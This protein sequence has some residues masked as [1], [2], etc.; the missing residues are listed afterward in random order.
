[1][2]NGASFALGK[3]DQAFSFDGVDDYVWAP[4][5][6][7]DDLQTLTIEAWVKLNSL[8]DRIQ[9]FVTLAPPGL[10]RAVLRYGL[11]GTTEPGQ[12]HFYM[13]IG[14]ESTDFTHLA[15]DGVLQSGV[16]HHVAGTYDGNYMRLYLDGVEVGSIEIS[17]PVATGTHHGV[18]LSSPDEPLD[19]LLDEVSIY[20]RALSASEILAIY[21]A[22]PSGKCSIDRLISN[23]RLHPVTLDGEISSSTEWSDTVPCQIALD[24]V[25]GWPDRQVEPSSKVLTARFKNDD[26]WLYLLYQIPWPIVDDFSVDPQDSASISLFWGSYVPPWDYSDASRLSFGGTTYDVYGWD[27]THWYSDTEASPPG[28]NDV[29]GAASHDGTYYWFEFKKRLDSGDGRDWSFSPGELMG[30]PYAPAETPHLIVSVWDNSII[31]NYEQYVSLQLSPA[32]DYGETVTLRLEREDW[33]GGTRFWLTGSVYPFDGEHQTATLQIVGPHGDVTFEDIALDQAGSYRHESHFQ[34]DRGYYPRGSLADSGLYRVSVFYGRARSEAMLPVLPPTGSAIIVA[35]YGPVRRNPWTGVRENSQPAVNELADWAYMVMLGRLKSH[36][37]IYLLHPDSPYADA[38]PTVVNLQYAIEDWA[39]E[40]FD[41]SE[42]WGLAYTPLTIYIV[43]GFGEVGY[44]DINEDEIVSVFL[45]ADWLSTLR[46]SVVQRQMEAGVAPW[47][48]DNQPMVPINIILE[49]PSSAVFAGKFSPVNLAGRLTAIVCSSDTDPNDASNILPPIASFSWKFFDEILNG[50]DMWRAWIEARMFIL[51]YY[52]NQIPRVEADGDGH[53]GLSDELE[54]HGR[55]L[56]FLGYPNYPPRFTTAHVSPWPPRVG[57]PAVME[58]NLE[59]DFGERG[60]VYV[61]VFPPEGVAEPTFTLQLAET[62]SRWPF[63]GTLQW[64]FEDP[65]EWELLY[66]GKDSEGLP[67]YPSSRH[68]DQCDVRIVSQEFLDLPD[69]V[70][71]GETYQITLRKVLRSN[72]PVVV[73]VASSLLAPPDCYGSF[74][75]GS[76]FPGAGYSSLRTALIL[77][78]GTGPIELYGW[79]GIERGETYGDPLTGLSTIDTE[80]TRMHTWVDPLLDQGSVTVTRVEKGDQPS[81]GKIVAQGTGADFPATS[82]F[83]VFLKIDTPSGTLHN[84][85]PLRLQT[86]INDIPPEGSSYTSQNVVPLFDE[87][88]NPAGVQLLRVEL[89]VEKTFRVELPADTDV[90]IDETAYIHFSQAGLHDFT[91]ENR[92]ERLSSVRVE[93]AGDTDY[94]NNRLDTTH[95]FECT[96]QALLGTT[97]TSLSAILKGLS[98]GIILPGGS[99]LEDIL[100]SLN[101]AIDLLSA[102][103]DCLQP[104][105]PLRLIPERGHDFFDYHEDAIDAIFDAI[106]DGLINPEVL[107]QLQDLVVKGI[108][109][110]DEI[111]AQTSIDDAIAAGADAD[112]VEDACKELAKAQDQVSQGIQAGIAEGEFFGDAA[113]SFGDAWIE[114]QKAIET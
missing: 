104:D 28:Q 97:V 15:V 21:E 59:L 51:D 58:A 109:G 16:W 69:M 43:S 32:P 23:W 61:T 79:T 33:N 74:S 40:R 36:D 76:E 112:D 96:A 90:V 103:Q 29:E 39:L 14:D 101:E 78:I 49:F 99:D 110:S 6:G 8:P 34:E 113:A 3:V 66:V 48:V 65:G 75:L 89:K 7:I 52:G 18:R 73:D 46:D 84:E 67:A 98:T 87:Q 54:L 68:F 57:E 106:G 80:I 25:W 114:A 85:E 71:P 13:R 37:S 70:N 72:W 35:G 91:F 26:T 12:L 50:M 41:T 64:D 102:S 2:E 88:G 108:L 24:R 92:I 95:T 1:M 53:P 82:F 86:V 63:S 44:F 94:T 56:E 107:D 93:R 55:Y 4:G 62:G 11:F 5:T 19:G 31:S 81:L 20:N 42:E 22:G 38:L 77:D 27:D 83:Q 105:D 10:E 17:G 111:V 9:R 100:E 30:S 60:E 45:L 47:I